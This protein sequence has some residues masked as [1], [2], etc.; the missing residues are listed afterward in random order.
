M[1]ILSVNALALDSGS[2]FVPELSDHDFGEIVAHYRMEVATADR[3]LSAV[4]AVMVKRYNRE[5]EF[6]SAWPDQTPE[7]MGFLISLVGGW[8]WERRREVTYWS[9][10]LSSVVQSVHRGIERTFPTEFTYEPPIA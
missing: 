10:M 3:L 4:F 9:R 5:E 2:A 7:Y 1:A 8:G 6:I